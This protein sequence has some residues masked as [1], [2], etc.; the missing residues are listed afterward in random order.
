MDINFTHTFIYVHINKYKKI[1]KKKTKYVVPNF[2][3]NT[4]R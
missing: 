3:I 2:L 4:I 1:S